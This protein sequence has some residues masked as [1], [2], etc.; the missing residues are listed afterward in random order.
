M[1]R[2]EL[3]GGA[4]CAWIEVDAGETS[5]DVFFLGPPFDLTKQIASAAT[6]IDNVQRPA[7]VRIVG[8]LRKPLQCR[9]IGMGQYIDFGKI[10]QT[11][12]KFLVV[13]RLIHPLRKLRAS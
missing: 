11:G 2:S 12:A 6:D 5:H 4:N 13:A 3:T 7:R 9:T 8:E 10:A 1:G